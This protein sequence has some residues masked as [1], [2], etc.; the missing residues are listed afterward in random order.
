[1]TLVIPGVRSAGKSAADQKRVATPADAVAS[2][3]DYLVVGR[4]VT[5]AEDPRAELL[6]ILDEISEP[7]RMLTHGGSG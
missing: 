2:G 7:V 5:R 1:L 3:A 6:K 4:Q